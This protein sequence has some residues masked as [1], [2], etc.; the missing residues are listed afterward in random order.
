MNVRVK[1][2]CVSVTKAINGV[3]NLETGKY[4]QKPVFTFKFFPVSSGSDENKFSQAE[5]A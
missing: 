2:H 1:L 3:N 5:P 4:E